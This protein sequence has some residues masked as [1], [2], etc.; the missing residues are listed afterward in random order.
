MYGMP[1]NQFAN[2]LRV[3]QIGE[4]AELVKEAQIKGKASRT[5]F[6]ASRKEMKVSY[7]GMFLV[8]ISSGEI[9][10]DDDLA[11]SLQRDTFFT[12]VMI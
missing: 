8:N 12:K 9:I 1:G 7:D 10:E 4:V 3:G 11:N 5:F 6:S 2:V